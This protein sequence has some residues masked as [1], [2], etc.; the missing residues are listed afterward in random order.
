MNSLDSSLALRMTFLLDAS[1]FVPLDEGELTVAQKK[2][3]TCY[4]STKRGGET[5]PLLYKL[6]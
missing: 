5:P 3:V 4:V 1:P 6:F 2:D